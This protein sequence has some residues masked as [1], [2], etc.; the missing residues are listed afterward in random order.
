MRR[1]ARLSSDSMVPS[2]FR[3]DHVVHFVDDP[4]S[5]ARLL[6]DAGFRSLAGGHHPNWGTYNSLCHFGLPYVEFLGVEDEAL[7][8]QPQQND[9]VRQ[10]VTDLRM[11]QG[12]GRIAIRTRHL[13]AV[14]ENLRKFGLAVEGPIPGQRQRPDGRTLRWSLVFARSPSGRLPL[15]FF[16]QWEDA[17][18][19][20]LLDLKAQ[21]LVGEHPLGNPEISDIYFVVGDPEGVAGSWQEWFSL[22][23]RAQADGLPA[24]SPKCTT[25]SLGEVRLNFCS[26][27]ANPLAKKTF[28]ERGER[29]FAIGLNGAREDSAMLVLGAEYR[30]NSAPKSDT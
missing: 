8:S 30:I 27:E 26:P 6:R 5:S 29:P 3:L 13:D 14:A 7:A 15:P 10:I 23:F 11:G 17:D 12:L 28:L 2:D 21:G 24:G 25:L 20:R 1:D 16:I 18:D 4:V 9:L 19:K 22:P